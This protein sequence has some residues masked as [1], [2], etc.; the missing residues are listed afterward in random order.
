MND[1]RSISEGKEPLVARDRIVGV[2]VQLW[3][4]T[5]RS[6]EQASYYI[7]PK[8][9]GAFERSWNASPSWE[10][11]VSSDDSDFISQLNLFYSII[12]Q[13]EIPFYEKIGIS[14]HTPDIC[15]VD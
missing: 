9:L 14:Y 6:F 13:Y 8:A 12:M 10:R 3:T 4:E 7:F 15:G 2:Q 5:I 11:S 1:L